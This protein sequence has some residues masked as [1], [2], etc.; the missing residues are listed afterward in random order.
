MSRT[1]HNAKESATERRLRK[2]L[3]KSA[4]Q[5]AAYVW[6]GFASII[7]LVLLVVYLIAAQPGSAP[8]QQ[9][10]ANATESPAVEGFT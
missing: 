10:P 3:N 5:Q 1:A 7:L 6:A 2:Q 8:L 4:H 9:Q